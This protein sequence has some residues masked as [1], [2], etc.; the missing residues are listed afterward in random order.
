MDY[1]AVFELFDEDKN[2]T[3]SQDELKKALKRFHLVSTLADGQI[4]NLL[5]LIDKQKK[6]VI[7]L[8]DFIAF[9]KDGNNEADKKSATSDIEVRVARMLIIIF[10]ADVILN[11]WT[12]RFQWWI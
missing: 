1:K 4:P 3:I 5:A 7:S 12:I 8:E 11:L 10:T 6:G 9:A 2:G